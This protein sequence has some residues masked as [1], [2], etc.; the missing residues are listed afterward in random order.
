MRGRKGITLVDVV[1]ACISLRKQHRRLG[2][3]NVRLELG[4]GSMTTISN[5]LKTLALRD[6]QKESRLRQ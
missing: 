5:H 1:R 4:R 2:P 6:I 3:S